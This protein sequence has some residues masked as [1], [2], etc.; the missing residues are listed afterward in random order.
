M[1]VVLL[2][3]HVLAA[4]VFIGPVTVA[5][6]MFPPR[7][8]ATLDAGGPDPVL[9]TLHRITRVYAVAG[10]AVPVFGIATGSA[11]GVLGE[12]WLVVSMVLT[13]V[14]A[15]ILAGA[16]LPGQA[17]VLTAATGDAQTRASVRPVA[18]RLSMVT[19]VFALTWAVVVVLM[20]ARPGSTTGA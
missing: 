17:A 10:V 13:A 16:V 12:T 15:V 7:A 1:S 8:R 19:G 4:I 11:M 14:A 5:A 6:S 2:S 18:R 9:E 20:I 3:I